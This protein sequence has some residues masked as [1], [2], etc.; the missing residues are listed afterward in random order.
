MLDE[1]YLDSLARVYYHKL[2]QSPQKNHSLVPP[3]ELINYE[4]YMEVLC[5]SGS[6][7]KLITVLSE[8]MAIMELCDDLLERMRLYEHAQYLD[9][10]H[11]QDSLREHWRTKPHE[12]SLAS[13]AADKTKSFLSSTS[14]KLALK[15]SGL[16]NMIGLLGAIHTQLLKYLFGVY[17]AHPGIFLGS[18]VAALALQ[19]GS[20]YIEESQ[21]FSEIDNITKNLTIVTSN[22][23]AHYT[24][25]SMTLAQSFCGNE[26]A[27]EEV[28]KAIK[29]LVEGRQKDNEAVMLR[30][31]DERD[32][33]FE[34]LEAV[35]D[36]EDWMNVKIVERHFEE[37]EK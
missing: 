20:E 19:L 34:K 25:A 11:T 32:Q 31:F 14:S 15:L 8:W 26:S 37:T 16:L 30:H 33:I 28:Y 3:K 10:K 29:A 22:L 9:I 23:R 13:A 6:Y 7:E 4:R 18:I 24:H 35:Q 1:G 12:V 17:F 5:E 27:A 21:L 36:S 2:K